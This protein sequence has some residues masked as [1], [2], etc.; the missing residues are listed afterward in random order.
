MEK[1]PTTALLSIVTDLGHRKG[2]CLE[3][4]KGLLEVDVVLL[5]VPL[6][7]RKKHFARITLNDHVGRTRAA[8]AALEV[9]GKIAVGLRHSPR[10]RHRQIIISRRTRDIKAYKHSKHK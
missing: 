7:A 5:R 4:R 6:G 9:Q 2:K 10:Q 1:G 8:A 3:G